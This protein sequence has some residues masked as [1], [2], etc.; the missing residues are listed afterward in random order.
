MYIKDEQLLAEKLLAIRTH[1]ADNFQ[2]LTDFDETLTK[3]RYVDG[4]KAD[5][6]FK[7]IQESSLLTDE[8]RALARTMF[9]TY[10]PIERDPEILPHIKSQFMLTWW[11]ENLSLYAK[12]GFQK[13]AY[14]E[15]T[16]LS[17]VLFRHG[18]KEFMHLIIDLKIPIYV[19]SGGITE[20]IEAAFCTIIANNEL[21]QQ[22]AATYFQ[23]MEIFS[24][25]FEY[26][27]DVTIGYKEPIIHI[28]NKQE[29][30]YSNNRKLN[31]NI[32]VMG[33]LIADVDMV[34]KEVH[35]VVLKI[36]Y[37]NNL[38]KHGH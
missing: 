37:L 7:A 24:N 27:N 32:L 22:K 36:G 16:L 35:D 21:D 19:V 28:M 34:K 29:V 6:A 5:S 4:T 11:E 18:I 15:I 30:I 25:E 12:M 14:F 13:E 9:D 8:I 33:D 17:K 2:I 26:H 10:H 23:L 31:K 38:K 20:I 1:G 3:E